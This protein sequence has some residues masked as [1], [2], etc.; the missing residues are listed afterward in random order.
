MSA[1]PL[2]GQTI[3]DRFE[4]KVDDNSVLSTNESLNF[5]N[6]V[7]RSVLDYKFWVWLM[8]E[9]TGTV[10]NSELTVPDDFKYF[11]DNYEDADGSKQQVIY[12]GTEYRP[13][14][15][16]PFSERRLHRDQDGWCY[17]DAVNNKIVFTSDKA[18]GKVAEFDY[19]Y[20]PDN[21]TL[22]TSPVFPAR[23]HDILFFGM[24][25]NFPQIDNTPKNRSYA[26]EYAVQYQS[27]L[28]DMSYAN[29]KLYGRANY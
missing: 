25:T 29:S 22:A 15:V 18:N 17:Y 4:V 11:Y 21:L 27:V 2:T 28:D 23:F 5:L 6:E 19:V 7:Y 3:I 12:I 13:Y 16:I 14:F 26:E 8:K 1:T 9:G 24:A 10:S 20:D